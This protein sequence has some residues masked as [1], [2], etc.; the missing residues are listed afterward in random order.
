MIKIIK[1]SPKDFLRVAETRSEII[2]IGEQL[3]REVTTHIDRY[4]KY[5]K[6]LDFVSINFSARQFMSMPYIEFMTVMINNSSLDFKKLNIEI[7]EASLLQNINQTKKIVKDLKK[8]GIEII[9]DD[10]GAG[11]SSLSY[12]LEYDI[13]R[14]KIDRYII[15]NI[16]VE[17]KYRKLVS[18]L[19]S[20]AKIHDIQVIA[21][22]V[23]TKQQ[24]DMVKQL[25]C[26]CAQGYYI[27][28][29]QPINKYIKFAKA[30]YMKTNQINLLSEERND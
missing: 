19:V 14:I 28:H 4:I 30:H 9:L 5:I 8:L 27:S 18:I 26:N 20:I 21:K 1:Y 11:Y 17:E 16:L 15:N 6:N 2:N 13:K 7:N 25:G 10:Y 3:I 12:L 24:Y 29:P 22:G 23:E